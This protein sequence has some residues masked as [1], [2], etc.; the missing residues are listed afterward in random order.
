MM[1]EVVNLKRGVVGDY[2]YI[3]RP[4]I[5][6]NPW[7]HLRVSGA[8]FRVSTRRESIDCYRGWLLGTDPRF[9]HL[10]QARRSEILRQLPGLRG[11]RLACYCAPLPCHGH[12]LAELADATSRPAALEQLELPI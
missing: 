10:D 1:T 3:G 12:V 7:S 4:S 2:V 9:A 11:K 5:F 8:H 6:G